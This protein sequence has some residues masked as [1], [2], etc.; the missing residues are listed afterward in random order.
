MFLSDSRLIFLTSLAAVH[1]CSSEVR[2]G[3]RLMRK[4]LP[5]ESY[6]VPLGKMSLQMNCWVCSNLDIEVLH[7]FTGDRP[8]LASG[9]SSVYNPSFS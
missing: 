8:D 3:F 4:K 6:K 7:A 1:E 9:R 5:H 2:Q